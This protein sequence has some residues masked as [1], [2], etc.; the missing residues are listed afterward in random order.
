MSSRRGLN[1][2]PS[3]I[4]KE[5]VNWNKKSHIKMLKTA[6]FDCAINENVAVSTEDGAFAL[7]FRPHPREFAIQ[8]KKKLIMG[9]SPQGGAVR[10]WNRLM[11][12]ITA[13]RRQESSQRNRR[14]PTKQLFVTGTFRWLGSLHRLLY[15]L[16]F[17]W[18]RQAV[19]FFLNW[20]V[21]LFVK[22]SH[23]WN[24]PN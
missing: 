5:D 16:T 23:I 20:T 18:L 2:D 6:L 12:Y 14:Q 24:Y 11:H 10:R 22:E 21:C 15:F 8:G 3:A 13:T 7:C 17:D 1:Y 9:V 19:I 4:T